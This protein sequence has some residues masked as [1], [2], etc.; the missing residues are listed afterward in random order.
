M[1]ATDLLNDKAIRFQKHYVTDGQRKARVTYSEG[2]IFAKDDG[3]KT[4]RECI[5]LYAKGYADGDVLGELFPATYFNDSDSM[6]DYSEKGLVRFFPGDA[7]YAA[8]KARYDALKS[9]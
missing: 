1:N 4:L 5:T 2:H 3:F 8:A 6:T 9:V 7:L